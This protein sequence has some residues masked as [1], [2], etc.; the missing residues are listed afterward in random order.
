MLVTLL[1]PVT[2]LV[3]GNIFLDEPVQ[4]KE[5]IGAAII[6][7]GLL[8]INGRVINRLTGMTPYNRRSR[9]RSRPAP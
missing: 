3:L 8:F 5:I 7:A 2:A 1:I 4:S 6:G 9:P